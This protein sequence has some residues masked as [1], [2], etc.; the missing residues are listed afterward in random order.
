MADPNYTRRILTRMMELGDASDLTFDCNGALF[1]VH[2][3]VV[4]QQSAPIKAAVQGRFD[5]FCFLFFF[6][7]RLL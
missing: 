7:P 6:L 1:R 4:C 5:V 2:T 3:A